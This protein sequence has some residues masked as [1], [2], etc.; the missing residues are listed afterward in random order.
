MKRLKPEISPTLAAA[1]YDMIER[2]LRLIVPTGAQFHIVAPD[3]REYGEPVTPVSKRTYQGPRGNAKYCRA[4]LEGME[5]NS[6]RE[7]G[8]PQEGDTLERFASALNSTA[9]HMWGDGTHSVKRSENGSTVVITRFATAEPRKPGRPGHKP[10]HVQAELMPAQP[11]LL[12][13]V[14]VRE[15]T[16]QPEG[17]TVIDG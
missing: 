2:A 8:P 3:G 5:P 13:P 11:S 6:M 16:P 12:A 14:R 17:N 1:H 9:G 7:C 10:E 15:R 4:M